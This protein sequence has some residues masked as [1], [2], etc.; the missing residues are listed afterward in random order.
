MGVGFA[1][2]PDSVATAMRGSPDTL[3]A[4]YGPGGTTPAGAV[5]YEA[6]WQVRWNPVRAC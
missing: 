2:A 3:V 1:D 4:V 6:K 5:T